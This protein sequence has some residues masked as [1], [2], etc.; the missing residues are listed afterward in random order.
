MNK[1]T[2][3]ARLEAAFGAAP[4]EEYFDEDMLGLKTYYDYRRENGLDAFYLDDITWDDLALTD[5]YKRLNATQTSSGEQYLYYQLRTPAQD[6]ETY[7]R[8]RD[9]LSLF[10]SDKALRLNVQLILDKLGKRRAANTRLAFAPMEHATLWHWVT[11]LL[12]VLL[13]LCIIGAFFSSFFAKAILLLVFANLGFHALMANRMEKDIATINYSVSMVTAC[14]RL[15]R[16]REA[17][18]PL[19]PSFLS[20]GERARA[21]SRTG[22]FSIAVAGDLMTIISAVFLLDL[23]AYGRLKKL[24]SKHSADIHLIHETLGCI[25]ASIAIASYRAGNPHHCEPSID[26][27]REA[28]P[29]LRIQQMV[30]PLFAAPVPND[31][32]AERS[33]LVTGANASGKSSFIKA[34]TINVILAQ[35]TCTALASTYAAPSYRIYSSMALRDSVENGD[36][37]FM[38][39]I[40]SIKRIWDAAKAGNRVFCAI[41]EV[42]RGTNTV[43]RIAASSELL[44]ALAMQNTLCIAATHDGELCAMLPMYRQVHFEERIEDGVIHFDYLLKEGPAT[45]QN[46]I[47]LLAMLGFDDEIVQSAAQKAEQYERTKSW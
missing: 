24:L 29:M 32:E 35:S 11:I 45:T 8:H 42:L 7:Q 39:E 47:K 27:S 25:D 43:E 31:L 26:F 15:K 4:D 1:A 2:K 30:H 19:F 22:G 17:L 16:Y 23:L 9:V 5:V 13:P 6:V 34:A 28:A 3:L 36:S 40:K 18:T 33:L 38:V 37:Y 41:D 21:I 10:S 20:A 12:A 14:L 44:K 46:A